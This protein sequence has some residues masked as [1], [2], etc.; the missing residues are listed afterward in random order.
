VRTP[1]TDFFTAVGVSTN[2]II[3]QYF[4]FKQALIFFICLSYNSQP[5]NTEKLNGDIQAAYL[6]EELLLLLR[7][8]PAIVLNSFM[9]RSL[10]V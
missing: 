6:S 10:N 7:I 9:G 3:H 8:S 2:R 5:A 1:H 4:L